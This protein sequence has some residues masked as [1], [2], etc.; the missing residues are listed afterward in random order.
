M[1]GGK[2]YKFANGTWKGKG[3]KE[4]KDRGKKNFYNIKRMLLSGSE[5]DS[6][7]FEVRYFEIGP[8]GYSSLE[9]HVHEHVVFVIKGKGEVLIGKEVYSVE[10]MDLIRIYPNTLHRFKNVSQ[11]TPFG[12]ICIVNKVRDKPTYPDKKE[13]EKLSQIKSLSDIIKID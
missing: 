5:D 6:L 10:P 3:F 9:H 7:C 4:Y 12:F 8:G 1:R 2:V 13:I 11:S